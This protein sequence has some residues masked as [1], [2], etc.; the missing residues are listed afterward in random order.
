[1]AVAE[2]AQLLPVKKNCKKWNIKIEIFS[3]K[4]M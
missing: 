1:V 2:I 4:K 3:F